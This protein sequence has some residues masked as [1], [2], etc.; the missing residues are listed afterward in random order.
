MVLI[1]ILLTLSISSKQLVTKVA[2]P[3]TGGSSS[4]GILT[5]TGS[6]IQIVDARIN[7]SIMSQPFYDYYHVH[8]INLQ[9]S[10]IMTN[11]TSENASILLLYRPCWEGASFSF[12]NISSL[13]TSIEGT[14]LFF[15]N[16]TLTNVTHPRDLPSEFHDRFPDWVY[17]HDQ[18]WYNPAP[19]TMLNLSIGPHQSVILQFYDQITVTNL[20]QNLTEV[21]FGLGVDQIK[22]DSTRIRV[23]MTVLDGSQFIDLNPYPYDIVVETQEGSN[24]TYTWDVQSPYSPQLIYGITPEPIRA[25]FQIQMEVMEYYLPTIDPTPTSGPTTSPTSS[26]TTSPNNPLAI[27]VLIL[28]IGSGLFIIAII[29][30]WKRWD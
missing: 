28:S 4:S 16:Q 29:V 30:L 15:S 20:S 1:V 8:T 17:L 9:G 26:P 6:D 7:M 24:Y 10:F 27:E 13:E 3:P 21:G 12:L 18:F 19:F 5:S 22:N 23:Q 14:P 2:A 25:G 11:P